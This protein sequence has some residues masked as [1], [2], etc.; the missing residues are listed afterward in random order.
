MFILQDGD[1]RTIVQ[2]T[3][4][5]EVIDTDQDVL[6]EFYAPWCGHCKELQPKYSAL[7]TNLK[8]VKTVVI[9][10]V[11]LRHTIIPPIDVI[12]QC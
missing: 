9:A 5:A 2:R 4:K 8:D 1:V 11:C 12:G 7:A 3:F 6:V 10:K